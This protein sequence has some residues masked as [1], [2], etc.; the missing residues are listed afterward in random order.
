MGWGLDRAWARCIRFAE[1]MQIPHL[2]RNDKVVVRVRVAFS[3]RFG[4]QVLFM[5]SARKQILRYAQDDK[6]VVKWV[7]CSLKGKNPPKL[8]PT[9]E[10]RSSGTLISD[11]KAIAKMG[12]PV[13]WFVQKKIPLDI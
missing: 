2:T 5:R 13:L 3:Q 4:R 11:D 1:S 10:E 9:N 12:H 8:T 6:A 7:S